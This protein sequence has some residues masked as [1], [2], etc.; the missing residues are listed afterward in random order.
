MNTV[1]IQYYSKKAIQELSIQQS[2]KERLS[3]AWHSY[4]IRRLR[5]ERYAV[6]E[7]VINVLVDAQHNGAAFAEKLDDDQAFNV[8]IEKRQIHKSIYWSGEGEKR[9]VRAL[10]KHLLESW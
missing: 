7:Q 4:P 6:V 1:T 8:N 9:K 2:D 5:A 10:L 3:F